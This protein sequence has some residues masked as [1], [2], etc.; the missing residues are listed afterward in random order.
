MNADD[1]LRNALVGGIDQYERGRRRRRAALVGG[2]ATLVVLIVVGFQV[3]RDRPEEV[4]VADGGANPTVQDPLPAESSSPSEPSERPLVLS[5]RGHHIGD[6]K[7]AFWGA[8]D[9]FDGDAQYQGAILDTVTA[10]LSELP[11]PP[12]VGLADRAVAGGGGSLL[13]C[14]DGGVSKLWTDADGWQTI[15]APFDGAG[16]GV[17]THSDYFVM[18]ARPDRGPAIFDPALRV[19][20]GDEAPPPAELAA[21]GRFATAWSFRTD[22]P[23]GEVFVVWPA[24]PARTSHDGWLFV[25][26]PEPRWE[27][28]PSIP[29]PAPAF[30]S[31]VD[32]GGTIVVGGGLPAGGGGSERFV[33][34]ALP[35]GA[36]TWVEIDVDAG[37]PTP[38][39]CNLGSQTMLWTGTDLL[40]HLGALG[41][42]VDRAGVL[43]S[44]TELD[45]GGSAELIG[46]GDEALR[47][48]VLVEDEVLWERSD[49]AYLLSGR[50]VLE[51]R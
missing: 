2:L 34:W 16:Y 49:G 50:V 27:P 6:G 23:S 9:Q 31:V 46:M 12:D 42:G 37:E 33:L 1:P 44:V 41:S 3:V 26:G 39:E 7:V 17:W 32:A 4:L 22:Q 14:C 28:L 38:C 18:P 24:P 45:A 20:G 5:S 19:S 13:V 48:I 8:F 30:V 25:P 43:F 10:T 35:G 15:D 36:D 11:T 40:V 29:G 47:P 21:H 51:P